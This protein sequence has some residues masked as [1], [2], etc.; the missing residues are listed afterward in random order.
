MSLLAVKAPKSTCGFLSFFAPNQCEVLA[1][2]VLFL[3]N[4]LS[5]LT[6]ISML[7]SK[8][9]NV[10]MEPASDST[11]TQGFANLASLLARFPL[12]SIPSTSATTS[13]LMDFVDPEASENIWTD[14]LSNLYGFSA[15]LQASLGIETDANKDGG[16]GKLRD[17]LVVRGVEAISTNEIYGAEI[18]TEA[19]GGEQV[20]GKEPIGA[21][22]GTHM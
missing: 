6:F 15:A 9:F 20:A 13:P 18:A 1:D 17:L 19:E 3:R 2:L 21:K 11:A 4:P 12:A 5:V 16:I 10:D 22:V 14:P 8:Y 7:P